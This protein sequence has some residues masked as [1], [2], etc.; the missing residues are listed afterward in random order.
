MILSGRSTLDEGAGREAEA[1]ILSAE[2]KTGSPPKTAC[3]RLSVRRRV[4]SGG[5][6][7]MRPS[8]QQPARSG[9]PVRIFRQRVRFPSALLSPAL[10]WFRAPVPR[11][12]DRIR[13]RRCR[14][15][16]MTPFQVSSGGLAPQHSPRPASACPTIPKRNRAAG[17]SP[18]S[19]ASALEEL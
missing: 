14:R 2:P 8:R 15:C 11:N 18:R 16:G 13:G 12:S 3:S 5:R 7:R 6:S 17:N 19:G 9:L 4:S 10:R 1:R